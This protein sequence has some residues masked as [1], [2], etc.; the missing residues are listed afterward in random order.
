[1]K[2]LSLLSSILISLLLALPVHAEKSDMATLSLFM[3]KFQSL[4][5]RFEQVQPDEAIFE[6]NLAKGFVLIKRP[7]K[8]LW[9]Y[10][11]PEIQKIIVDGKNLWIFDE[12]VDQATVTP[13]KDIRE[14][15]PLRWLLYKTDLNKHFH[16]TLGDKRKG[17]SWFNLSP[18]K[19]ARFFQSIEVAI[20]GDQ[21]REIWMYQSP[22]NVT[23]VRFFNGV[24][25]GRLDDREFQFHLPKGV[26]L[27]GVPAS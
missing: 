16:I 10:E 21:L 20:E 18:K 23:K 22:E 11:E 17:L 26:D 8:L 1:M 6:Q 27:I 9:A 3:V 15:F 13:L 24:T 12:D 5:A 4:S 19:G 7:G 25:N 2:N 14:D